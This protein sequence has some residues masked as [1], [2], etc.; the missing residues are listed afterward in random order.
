MTDLL[1]FLGAAFLSRFD[2]PGYKTERNW[3][4]YHLNAHT[5]ND[6]ISRPSL[7]DYLSSS[8]IIL[9]QQI[10]RRACICCIGMVFK[11]LSARDA[12]AVYLTPDKYEK[13][14]K[15]VTCFLRIRAK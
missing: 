7:R 8:E 15:D 9:L 12:R 1:T 14:H 4:M 10:D 2:L 13:L 11:L 3:K 6:L 5:F